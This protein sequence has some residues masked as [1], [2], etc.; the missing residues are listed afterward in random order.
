M[1]LAVLLTLPA[2]A[3]AITTGTITGRVIDEAYHQGIEGIWVSVYNTDYEWIAEAYTGPDGTYDISGVSGPVKVQ[4]WDTT[5]EHLYI[6]EYYNNTQNWDAATV[7]NVAAGATVS[8]IN[9]VLAEG[10]HIK[11]TVIDE[12]TGQPLYGVRVAANF[13]EDNSVEAFTRADGTYDITG[14]KSGSYVVSFDDIST[15]DPAGQMYV[16]EFYPGASNSA[17]ATNVTVTAPSAVVGIDATM[18]RGCSI[19]GTVTDADTLMPIFQDAE[20]YWN[21]PN[22]TV[23]NAAGMEAGWTTADEN[24]YW[25]IGGLPDGTYKVKFCDWLYNDATGEYGG[26]LYTTQWYNDQAS[27]DSA[28]EIILN[29]SNARKG[30]DARM[31]SS[32]QSGSLSG[33][34]T[35]GTS[36]N[37]LPCVPITLYMAF[38]NG[39]GGFWWNMV[40]MPYATT[41]EA[42]QFTY[43]YLMPGTYRALVGGWEDTEYGVTYSAVPGYDYCYYGGGTELNTASDIEV[44][45]GAYVG[46]TQE[47]V[48]SEGCLPIQGTINGGAVAAGMPVFIETYDFVNGWW[49]TWGTAV[50]TAS[51]SWSYPAIAGET[52][53][54]GYNQSDCLEADPGYVQGW[55]PSALSADDAGSV[56]VAVAGPTVANGSVLS[57]GSITGRVTTAGNVPVQ[58]GFVAAWTFDGTY[59]NWTQETRTDSEGYYTLGGLLAGNYRVSFSAPWVN[60]TRLATEYYPDKMNVDLGQNVAVTQGVD[61]PG[62]NAELSPGIEFRLITYL[63]DTDVNFGQNIKVHAYYNDGATGWAEVAS[64]YAYGEGGG[65]TWFAPMRSGQ[66]KFFF[67]DESLGGYLPLWYQNKISEAAATVVDAFG[68]TLQVLMQTMDATPPNTT[69]NALGGYRGAATINLT[70]TDAVSGVDNTQWCLD[71]GE[72]FTGT[73]VTTDTVGP[74][75]LQ[76]FSVDKLGNAEMTRSVYFDV[77]PV[78]AA[79]PVA[80]A[81][82]S[83]IDT[84]IQASQQAFD[85]GSVDTVV[86]A[87]GYNWPDALGGAALA[88][89]YN[90]PIL[91]TKPG[92]LPT[93]VATEITRLG[94]GKAV[95]LGGT[96]AVSADVV[97][98]LKT[99]LGDENVTRVSGASRYDT[100]Q[101]IAAA[102]VELLG[103][104]YDG[105]AFVATG[106]KFPDALGASPLAAGASWPIYLANPTTGLATATKAAMQADGVTD[107]LLLGGTSAVSSAIETDLKGIYGSA[108][109][110]RLAGADRYATA[111]VVA[112]YGVD[113]AGLKWNKVAIATG[114]NFPDALAGGVLQGLDG[115]VML[116]TPGTELNASVN[117]KLTANKSQISEVR[118][119]GGLNAVTAAVRNAVNAI[120]Q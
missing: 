79:E 11:G 28:I 97:T 103:P 119:L 57:A 53:R 93:T 40:D 80:I 20:Y 85:A 113:H 67:E 27:E 74:H 61:T 116:L 48:R 109:V 108:R 25:R 83:R 92:D 26:L 2:S 33:T 107:V 114:S 98:Q 13:D 41:D 111:C 45:A 89:A 118:Y 73:T 63:D 64:G 62:I 37:P 49:N 55:Y 71:G 32:G 59:W 42:G 110:T 106:G 90:G 86:I 52:Y 101:A 56:V 3:M 69:T 117:A 9:A 51:G 30:V 5:W 35:D 44:A 14:L 84:A 54:I 50:T 99:L 22:I 38:D 96:S 65:E 17:S 70:A 95:I 43:D 82:E 7:V 16:T 47:L 10:A 77:L 66:Y 60:P 87:T 21:S 31:D 75:W 72:F 58:N 34:V 94:A 46:I 91:L 4:F 68:G 18:K 100:A 19:S 6:G 115:S 15:T 105:T 120:I 1:T 24:G 39:E 88:G 8:N 81:G 12:G 36:G 112:Q 104:G 29:A 76:Y 102:T 23:Y 78:D